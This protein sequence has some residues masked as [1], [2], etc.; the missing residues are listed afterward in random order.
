MK[1]VKVHTPKPYYSTYSTARCKNPTPKRTYVRILKT[2]LKPT[3]R[4]QIYSHAENSMPDQLYALEKGGFLARY[5]KPEWASYNCWPKTWW[6]TTSKGK[7]ILKLA[8]A[9]G[10]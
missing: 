10:V 7:K 9:N 8:E 6:K 1:L 4:C 2:C 3:T 5:T